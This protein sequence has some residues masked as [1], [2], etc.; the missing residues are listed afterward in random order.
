MHGNKFECDNHNSH[1]QGTWEE[2]SWE[3]L[4]AIKKKGGN[5]IITKNFKNTPFSLA[6]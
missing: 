4:M 2:W 1:F 3:Y 6:N 5:Y